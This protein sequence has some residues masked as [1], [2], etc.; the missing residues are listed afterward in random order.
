[1]T[2]STRTLGGLAPATGR[3][4][5]PVPGPAS[6]AAAGTAPRGGALAALFHA[7]AT[8]AGVAVVVVLALLAALVGT[9][10]FARQPTQ[11]TE[12]LVPAY[13]AA[14]FVLETLTAALLFAM[15]HVQRSRALLRLAAGYLFAAL[16]VPAWALTFPGVLSGLGVDAG[17]QTTAAIA[18]VRRLGFPLFVL[19][20]ALAPVC[21][22][23]SPRS[24][25]PILRTVL[26]V[27]GLAAVCLWLIVEGR[28]VLPGFMA[29]DRDVT[30]LWY[31]VPAVAILLYGLAAAILVW[32]R[33][34][35]LD[36]WVCLVLVSLTVELA[37]MSWLG[38]ATRLGVGWWAGRL[39]GLAAA[40]IVLLVL[41][42]ET[43]TVHLRLARAVAAERRA[44]QDRLTAMEA[45]SATIAHEIN[46]PLASMVTNADAGL[47][48]L[49]KAEP[50]IDMV[51]AALRRIVAD[52]HRANK[53]VVGIRTM[54]M[55]GAQER[56]PLDLGALLRET[57]RDKASEARAAGIAIDLDLDPALPPVIGNALQLRQVV[58]NLIENAIDAMTATAGRE[59][60]L[61]IAARG[62]ERGE[63]EVSVADTGG[64]VP[65][66]LAERIFEPFV[67]TKPE[68][69]GMGLMFCRAVVEAHGGRLWVAPARPRGAVF[70][71]SIP[72]ALVPTNAPE[73]SR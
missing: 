69:M 48:W 5:A 67:S 71:F 22:D 32:R 72:T 7:T 59:R 13:A 61:R 8:Q 36:M 1:M 30:R 39:Y 29:D 45:L 34:F 26:A 49:G 15:F 11:G 16:M 65:P 73:V 66:E 31:R 10:P 3:A 17:L 25:V 68:G 37:L 62:A 53:V 50:R 70:A 23:T 35:A 54:F 20:Y 9:A 33:R 27:A 6:G 28:P 46:Q 40:S 57:V 19:G 4:S 63:A 42:S 64:G 52:G 47:R 18:A 41:L 12:I 14:S 24:L 56:E 44:R 60:R 21:S 55:T 43:T 38:G 2:T 51:D 58:A